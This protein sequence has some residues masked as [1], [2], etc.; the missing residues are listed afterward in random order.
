VRSVTRPAAPG[1]ALAVSAKTA[2]E[3]TAEKAVVQK[4]GYRAFTTVPDSLFHFVRYCRV[5]PST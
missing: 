5:D 4:T 3:K 2:S 1:T